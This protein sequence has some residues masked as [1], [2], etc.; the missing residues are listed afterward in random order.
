MT[1]S[2]ALTSTSPHCHGRRRR[3]RPSSCTVCTI[4]CAHTLEMPWAKEQA[5]VVAVA[6]HVPIPSPLGLRCAYTD[7]TEAEQCA[8]QTGKQAR[9][10]KQ[11][12]LACAETHTHSRRHPSR[13]A[14]QEAQSDLWTPLQTV[15]VI[16]VEI[17]VDCLQR[18]LALDRRPY[19]IVPLRIIN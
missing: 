17:R 13:L 6:S 10:A 9:Q 14:I 18:R 11:A 3:R 12:R 1:P 16:P 2:I 4:V 19:S 15:P 8:P 5:C 7:S